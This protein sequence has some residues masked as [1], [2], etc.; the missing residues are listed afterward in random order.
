M[1]TEDL[2]KIV[3]GRG[4]R[5][6]ADLLRENPTSA[7]SDSDI[8]EVIAFMCKRFSVNELAGLCRRALRFFPPLG[9]EIE[10][11]PAGRL[12]DGAAPEGG[13]HHSV[14]AICALLL[15]ERKVLC[16]EVSLLDNPALRREV[17]ARLGGIGI[18]LTQTEGW[19]KLLRM[20]GNTA[21][22]P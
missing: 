7:M 22:K 20:E 16:S 10:V 21:D 4:A 5:P 12:V 18:V 13:V 11:A 15:V 2:S 14:T 3:C 17:E 1:E 6:S 19:W 8:D 9:D